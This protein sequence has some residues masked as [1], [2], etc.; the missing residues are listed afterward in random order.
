MKKSPARGRAVFPD[1]FY[2]TRRVKREEQAT[3]NAEDAKE[4][5]KAAEGEHV[6]SAPHP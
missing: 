6:A 2:C 4:D 5:A 1:C 3:A